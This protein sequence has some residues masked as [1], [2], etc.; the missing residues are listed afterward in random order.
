MNREEWRT[1]LKEA[2]TLLSLV[3]DGEDDDDA[4]VTYSALQR[5]VLL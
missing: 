1:L 4:S 3:S 2:R 5:A